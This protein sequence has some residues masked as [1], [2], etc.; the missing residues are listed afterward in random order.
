MAIGVL[1]AGTEFKLFVIL[2]APVEF[3]VVK[4]TGI[5][6]LPTTFK[7]FNTGSL[8]ASTEFE[9]FD[10]T[11]T[12]AATIEMGLFGVGSL[13]RIAEFN[14][15]TANTANSSII[16][17]ILYINN[18]NV[19]SRITGQLNVPASE[20]VARSA[21]FSLLPDAGLIDPYDWIGESVVINYIENGAV[22]RLFT[23]IVHLPTFDTTTGIVSFLCTD[24]LQETVELLP[25]NTIANVVAGYWDNAVFNEYVDGWTHAQERLSTQQ[26]SY[27][28]DVYRH[29]RITPWL[30]K[31]SADF[32]FDSSNVIFD[33]ESL[34]LAQRRSITN[35]IKLSINARFN[36]KW[37][38]E[39]DTT[40]KIN[41]FFEGWLLDPYDLP[42]SDMIEQSLN[43]E[44]IKNIEFGRLPSSSGLYH[45]TNTVDVS[46]WVANEFT[47]TLAMSAAYTVSKRWLQTVTKAHTVI[48][49]SDASIAKHGLL[50]IEKNVSIDVDN[51]DGWED[52][53]NYATPTGDDVGNGSHVDV[54]DI[55]YNNGVDT[56]LNV[57][58]TELLASHR[59]NK[60]TFKTPLNPHIDLNHTASIT[61]SNLTAMGK[62]SSIVNSINLSSGEAISTITLS[63]YNPNVGGQSEDSLNINTTIDTGT[64]E[65]KPP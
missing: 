6:Q 31:A 39:I 61:L 41:H 2:S 35:S 63:M 29:G 58:K 53:L 46:V 44:V 57:A 62:V 64:A 20:G 15:F 7:L 34:Q 25:Q 5:I 51:G 47:K 37:Q 49:K 27:D 4:S 22:S 28:M 8:S 14:I 9:L 56:A 19:T 38:K 18:V 32:V 65:Y 26:A 12:L 54:S 36:K 60:V 55:D 42:T 59:Q 13:S 3:D 1:T 50:Q 21:T 45:P 23:G 11:G 43:G 48:I 52:Y 17:M 33:S 16:G 24:A 40:W 30:P 10:N